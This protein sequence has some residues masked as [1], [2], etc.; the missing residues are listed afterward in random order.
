[1][2]YK[3]E[4]SISSKSANSKTNQNNDNLFVDMTFHGWNYSDTSK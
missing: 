1:M 2:W 3:M 4:Q